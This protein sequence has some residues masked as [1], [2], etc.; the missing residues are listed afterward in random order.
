MKDHFWIHYEEKELDC[1]WVHHLSVV[2]DEPLHIVRPSPSTF[3]KGSG[4][5]WAKVL[6]R[7]HFRA[8]CV[9]VFTQDSIIICAV[10]III[11]ITSFFLNLSFMCK[12]IIASLMLLGLCFYPFGL[13]SENLHHFCDERCQPGWSSLVAGLSSAA[14]FLCPVLATLVSNPIY[15]L[16]PWEAY[17]LL[18]S[19]LTAKQRLHTA[20]Q[21]SQIIFQEKKKKKNDKIMKLNEATG[22]NGKFFSFCNI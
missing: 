19:Q 6:A 14:A 13:R 1:C 3:K 2:M 22:W 12:H 15:D 10:I 18:W 4:R 17:L 5:C 20:Q 21:D 8:L 16:N 9:C 7:R 11:I